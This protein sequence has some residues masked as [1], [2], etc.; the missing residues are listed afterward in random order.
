MPC[1][2]LRLSFYL[3]LVP[4]RD[5]E[6]AERLKTFDDTLATYF[7]I[8][9]IASRAMLKKYGYDTNKPQARHESDVFALKQ[10]LENTFV[11]IRAKMPAEVIGLIQVN[12][13]QED[14]LEQ[15]AREIIQ[16]AKWDSDKIN[17]LVA[18]YV[19]MKAIGIVEE[20]VS[21]QLQLCQ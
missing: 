6:V 8:T 5:P 9:A 10:Q 4:G 11:E 12:P 1:R 2:D 14:W 3:Q 16:K 17:R 7:D 13:M 19:V 18:T 21:L 20:S 15:D